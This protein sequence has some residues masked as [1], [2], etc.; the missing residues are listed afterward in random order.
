MTWDVNSDLRLRATRSRDIRAANLNDLFLAPA[1]G[2]G[3]GA[4]VPGSNQ[5]VFVF[6][7]TGGVPTLKP[8]IAS[9]TA[10]GFVYR[11]GWLP[12]FSVS[13]DRWQIGIDDAI[14]TQTSQQVINACYGV[15]GAA[16]PVS[17]GQ[18]ELNPNPPTADLAGQLTNARIH[19]GGANIARQDVAG[20]D[21]EAS[22]RR[23]LNEIWGL[24]D[25]PGSIDLRALGTH[26]TK[27]TQTANG[28]TQNYRNMVFAGIFPVAGGP[29]W[30]WLITGTYTLGPSST[31][32]TVR[33]ISQAVINNEPRNSAAAVLQNDIG[34]RGYLDINEAWNFRLGQAETQLFAKIEN[35][36]D[37]QPPKVASNAPTSHAS[38]GVNG[39]YYD[40]IGRYWRVGLRF[41]F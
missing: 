17:C 39:E 7:I 18:I 1:A 10:Y 37:T 13:V 38:S 20:Y 34:A 11:P 25:L 23:N 32:L 4:Q 24:G 31:T 5:Q 30:R 12:G 26:L 41:K 33:T 15:G 35:V 21:I 16:N 28:V 3:I 40:L 14:V 2:A 9:T 29:N 36:L 22:Y 8:E 6:Q 19:V 27:F